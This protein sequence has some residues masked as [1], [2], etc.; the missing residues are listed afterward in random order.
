MSALG[1]NSKSFVV[2]GFQPQP[3][4]ETLWPIRSKLDLK[5]LNVYK[6]VDMKKYKT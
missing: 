4:V 5:P 2:E 3:V 1:F 6:G